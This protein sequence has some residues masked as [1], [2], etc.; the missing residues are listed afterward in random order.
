M[1]YNPPGGSLGAAFARLF[2]EDPDMQIN[3]DL[4]HFK[5][6]METG[7]V[8]TVQGQPSGRGRQQDSTFTKTNGTN[9]RRN[10]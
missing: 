5:Q 4:R 7:E 6:I 10:R 2:G 3:E 1:R 9:G 8:A